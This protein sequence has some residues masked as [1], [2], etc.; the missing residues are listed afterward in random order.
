MIEAYQPDLS[1]RGKLRRRLALRHARRPAASA[2]PRP[3]VSFSF[4]DV[5][6]SAAEAGA[7]VLERAGVRGSF[8]IATALCDREGHMGRFAGAEEVRRLAAT[9]HEVGCHTAGHVDLA[10]VSA[11]LMEAEL[12]ANRA[13]LAGLGAEPRTFAYPYGEVGFAAKRVA[14]R[15]FALARTVQA[16]LVRRGSDLAQAPAVGIEGAD[17]EATALRWLRRAAQ[18]RAWLIL[19]THD[20]RPDPSPWGCTPEALARVVAEAQ[21]LGLHPVTVAE[22]AAARGAAA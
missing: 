10:R 18:E 8:Y 22:G 16:G 20:V 7:A 3:M 21:S 14:G 19:Y 9:G 17:G 12:D 4:D 1:L 5:P 6:A 11:A 13:A 2:P 15:R